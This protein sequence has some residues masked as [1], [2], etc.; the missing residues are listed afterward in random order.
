MT[1]ARTLWPALQDNAQRYIAC[2]ET[3]A[4]L[5]L[6]Q[7]A[8]YTCSAKHWFFTLPAA[9]DNMPTEAG[10]D[11]LWSTAEPLGTFLKMAAAWA[12]KHHVQFMVSHL[13]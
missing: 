7:L 4:Q 11:K 12:A 1:E 9:S 2:Y 6:A 10:L 5:A 8:H 3:L 13:S